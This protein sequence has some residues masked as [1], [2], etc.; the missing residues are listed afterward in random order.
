MPDLVSREFNG[1]AEQ[2]EHLENELRGQA[3]QLAHDLQ[4]SDRSPDLT[5]KSPAQVAF[6]AALS[7]NADPFG[8]HLTQDDVAY[9]QKMGVPMDKIERAARGSGLSMPA[10]PID[11]ATLDLHR[12]AGIAAPD[13]T[14]A[15]Y[16]FD[17]GKL[18]LDLPKDQAAN[19][20]ATL[21][22]WSADLHLDPTM[23]KGLA[24]HVV[25][26]G[27]RLRAFDDLKRASWVSQQ[28]A[29]LLKSCGGDKAAAAEIV[30]KATKVLGMSGIINGNE[31][32]SDAIINS[33]LI[34]SAWLL[35]TLANHADAMAAA[36]RA[37]KNL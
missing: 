11:A 12:E 33:P 30:A 20:H 16:N 37:K 5:A 29:S 1:T 24:E 35:Q 3:A 32:F 8:E 9:L 14:P 36:E 21:A 7:S 23:A 10:A 27:P 18:A 2:R 34:H 25:E 6:D 13:I 19:I 28:N 17:L 31:R 22:Q 4:V 15:A 26:Q